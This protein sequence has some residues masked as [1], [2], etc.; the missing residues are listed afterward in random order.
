VQ[1]GGDLAEPP[2]AVGQPRRVVAER[3][4]RELPAAADGG[5]ERGDRG[6]GRLERRALV[7]ERALEPSGRSR[8][9]PRRARG[10]SRA[11]VRAGLEPAVELQHVQLVE[12]DAAVRLLDAERPDAAPRGRDAGERREPRRDL[13]AL[14]GVD[15]LVAVRRARRGSARASRRRS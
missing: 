3:L 2:A 8:T 15:R 11:R 9:A 7:V 10:A 14:E 1:L 4:E 13:R 6:E 12:H 5:D